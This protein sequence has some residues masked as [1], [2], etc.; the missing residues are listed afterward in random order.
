MEG[1]EGKEMGGQEKWDEGSIGR[2][3]GREGGRE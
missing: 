3:G 1:R 2:E